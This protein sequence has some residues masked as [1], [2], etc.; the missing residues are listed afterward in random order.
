[1]TVPTTLNRERIL[2]VDDEEGMRELLLTLFQKSGY[3]AS[4]VPDAGEAFRRVAEI[5]PSVVVIDY[6]IAGGE[7]ISLIARIHDHFPEVKC[8]FMTG[9]DAPEVFDAA[10]SAGAV[11]TIRKPFDILVMLDKVRCLIASR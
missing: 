3:Q 10:R 7:G 9:Y 1:M 8:L 6:R 11:D 2:V 5:Q 4:A